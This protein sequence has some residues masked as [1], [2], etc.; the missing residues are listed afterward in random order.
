MN[1]VQV[2]LFKTLYDIAHVELLDLKAEFQMFS[3]T[4]MFLPSTSLD[5]PLITMPSHY[6]A[7]IMPGHHLS[8]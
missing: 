6:T 1:I 2:Y 8:T 5:T 7:S 3:L 4:S